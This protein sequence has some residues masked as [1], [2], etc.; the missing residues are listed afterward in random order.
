MAQ[1]PER[2]RA[3]LLSGVVLAAIGPVTQAALAEHGLR[4]GVVAHEY[5]IPALAAAL[6]RHLA[7]GTPS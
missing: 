2:D 6:A 5:T 1:V 4:A 7:A 3:R